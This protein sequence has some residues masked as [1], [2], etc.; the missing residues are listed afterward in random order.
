MPSPFTRYFIPAVQL[1]TAQGLISNLDGN[2]IRF[3]WDISRDNTNKPDAGTV[4][5]YNLSPTL[6][7]LI[8]EA[9]QALSAASGYLVTF[10]LGWERVPSTV[11]V[12]DVWDFVPDRRT[13][14][15]TMAIFRLG[16]GIKANRD[17][18]VGRSFNGVKIDI[19]LDYLVQI[20]PA[21][22]DAGGGGLGLIYPPESK[23][24]IKTAAA[25]LPIQSWGN[26]PA[27]AN[28]R[29]AIDLIMDTLGLEWRV[30]N[31]AFIAL[32]GGVINRPPVILRPGTGLIKYERRNDDGAVLEALANPDI[33]P[34]SQV[35][36][37]DNNG[38]PFGAGV[39][40][41]ERVNF[42]G[43]SDAESVMNIRA[44]KAVTV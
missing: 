20:P 8:L 26:I 35:I 21:P 30:Q 41:V 18:A 19:V 39:F 22:S 16:D 11:I 44:A 23:A 29:E 43:S 2:G 38:K 7:G 31:G 14:T 5:V 36:V 10:G 34:G 40:R 1:V 25:E 17:Q 24:L 15:D 3:E 9:W 6:T 27:G 28:T 37:Q 33:E 12:A 4:T 13:P 32:R 42:R